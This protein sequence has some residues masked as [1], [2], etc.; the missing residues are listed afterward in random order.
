[1]G[2]ELLHSVSVVMKCHPNE[3]I[4]PTTSSEISLK[5]DNIQAIISKEKLGSRTNMQ[6]DKARN[7]IQNIISECE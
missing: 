2:N 1:M 4:L 5:V 3:I 6:R 7:H